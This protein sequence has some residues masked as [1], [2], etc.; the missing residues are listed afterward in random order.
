MN[1]LP[2]QSKGF[3]TH[4][5]TP[6]RYYYRRKKLVSSFRHDPPKQ[7]KPRLRKIKAGRWE[8]AQ[9]QEPEQSWR[10][11][12]RNLE[13]IDARLTRCWAKPFLPLKHAR[14]AEAS[15]ACSETGQRAASHP[16]RKHK[17]NTIKHSP[18]GWCSLVQ[19]RQG[20]ADRRESG[21]L[22]SLVQN[23]HQL[24]GAVFPISFFF[25]NRHQVGC[26]QRK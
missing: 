8:A 15:L 11:A 4:R 20:E 6:T 16:S 10:S 5:P 14:V 13:S 21:R 24:S 2:I 12:W 3:W 22:W 18:F 9:L 23:Q 25:T 26:I 19:R 17:D 1:L 7:K